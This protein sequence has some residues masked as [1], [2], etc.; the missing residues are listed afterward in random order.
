M[1]QNSCICG[2]IKVL[3]DA[4]LFLCYNAYR[5]GSVYAFPPRAKMETPGTVDTPAFPSITKNHKPIKKTAVDH[6]FDHN[7]D[8]IRITNGV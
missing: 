3:L 1:L 8:H 6:M 4:T 2:I 7:G 5:F